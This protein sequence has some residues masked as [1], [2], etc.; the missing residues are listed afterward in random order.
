MQHQHVQPRASDPSLHHGVSYLFGFLHLLRCLS[1]QCHPT[2]VGRARHYL[3]AHFSKHGGCIMLRTRDACP[4]CGTAQSKKP[5]PA[6]GR[7]LGDQK[8]HGCSGV[9]R[10][11]AAP[12]NY[13]NVT[14]STNISLVKCL[15]HFFDIQMIIVAKTCP[16]FQNFADGY[17]IRRKNCAEGHTPLSLFPSHS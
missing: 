3:H 9:S 11:A 13:D 5:D 10:L 17:E 8:R 14:P 12:G 1:T 15:S 2:R 16:R 7:I 4:H 6:S